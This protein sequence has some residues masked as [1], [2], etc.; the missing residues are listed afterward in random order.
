MKGALPKGAWKER[1]SPQEFFR[2]SSDVFQ[3]PKSWTS[4]AFRFERV[5]VTNS[6][7]VEREAR[8]KSSEGGSFRKRAPKISSP[9][10]VASDLRFRRVRVVLLTKVPQ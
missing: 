6:A 5:R 9:N 10:L 4:K 2:D 3:P 7:R 1:G 8:E